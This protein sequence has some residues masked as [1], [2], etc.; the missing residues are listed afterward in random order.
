MSDW[1]TF[2]DGIRDDAGKLAKNELK[3]LVSTAVADTNE[4][5]KSVGGA[6]EKYLSQ[7]AS[8][9][10]TREEFAAYMKQQA[11]LARMRSNKAT[12]QEKARIQRLADGIQTLLIDG[13]S[14]LV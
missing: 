1:V 6:V 4:V 12:V 3:A 5:V 14:K 13:L 2:I 10:I 8:G 9:E 11:R 7:L